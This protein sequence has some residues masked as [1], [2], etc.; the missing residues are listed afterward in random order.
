[1]QIFPERS[2]LDS[3][4]TLRYLIPKPPIFNFF[5]FLMCA[6]IE[7]DYI[8]QPESPK[9]GLEDGVQQRVGASSWQKQFSLF[10]S[11]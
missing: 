9:P 2:E 5:F 11:R 3:Y 6:S 8:T 1:M 7:D 4:F 10:A